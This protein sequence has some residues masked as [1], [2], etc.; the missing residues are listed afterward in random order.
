[1][2]RKEKWLRMGQPGT[3]GTKATTTLTEEPAPTSPGLRK[4]THA[5]FELG[6]TKRAATITM[7]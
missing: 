6:S 7:T 5:A 1:M 3:S 2:M 4:P